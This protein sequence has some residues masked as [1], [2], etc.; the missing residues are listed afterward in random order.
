MDIVRVVSLCMNKP[1]TL[2]VEGFS[3][4]VRY[5]A[6]EYYERRAWVEY[7]CD[8]T[9]IIARDMIFPLTFASSILAFVNMWI[10]PLIEG[11]LSFG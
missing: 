3:S 10:Y 2:L 9:A 1:G 5:P 11:G 7:N 8:T 4:W 6:I